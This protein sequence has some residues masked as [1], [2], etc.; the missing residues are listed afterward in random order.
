MMYVPTCR[1]CL[2]MSADAVFL[3]ML[4]TSCI[5]VS[6]QRTTDKSL[7]NV[8]LMMAKSMEVRRSH[9]DPETHDWF[10]ASNTDLQSV[11]RMLGRALICFPNL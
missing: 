1:T 11:K 2:S 9:F 10:S 6:I 4:S 5:R 8:S 3:V 7:L